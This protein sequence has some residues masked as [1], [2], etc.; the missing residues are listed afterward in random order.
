[1]IN[2]IVSVKNAK[3]RELKFYFTGNTCSN[4]KTKSKRYVSNG[5]CRFCHSRAKEWDESFADCEAK[6]T[7]RGKP[8]SNLKYVQ[9][10]NG[11]ELTCT[12]HGKHRE[13]YTVKNNLN[14]KE[15]LGCSKCKRDG[16]KRRK[17]KN[18]LKY[19][20]SSAKGRRFPVSITEKYLKSI[21]E[22]QKNKCALS[23][24]AFTESLKPSLDRIDSSKGY[25][26]E[27]VQLV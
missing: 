23:G 13:W 17:A 26:E 7:W 4:C 6:S 25:I 15:Y 1:M 8:D 24:I 11:E 5:K 10:N 18:P 22:K 12:K 3:E 27:N 2:E 20:I 21:L 9:F 16:E 14:N 19:L